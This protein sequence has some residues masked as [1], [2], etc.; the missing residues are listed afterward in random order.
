VPTPTPTATQSGGDG[1][2]AYYRGCVDYY[3][4]WFVSYDG[5]VTWEAT[6]EWEYAGCFYVS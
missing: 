1:G 5:G 4:V 6:G 3:W 2:T